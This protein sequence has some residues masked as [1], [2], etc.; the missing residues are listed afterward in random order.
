MNYFDKKRER[1]FQ[2]N[3]NLERFLEEVNKDLWV[4]EKELMVENRPLFPV[5][6]IVGPLRSGSTLLMQWLANLG[7][8]SYPTNLLSRFYKAPII[9]AKIQL[10]L[11][12][13]RYNF[14]DEL[15]EFSGGVDFFSENGK[16]KG[17]LAPN[18]FWYFWRRFLPYSELDY[19]PTE[20]LLKQSDTQTM[21]A[22][23]A[24]MMSVFKKPMALKAMILNYNVDFLDQLFEKA[25][26]IH[27]T[28]DPLTNIASAL[29]ARKKQ[30]GSL[31][32]WYSFKIPEYYELKK[33]NPYEQVAGQI[34][35]INKAVKKELVNVA[36][37]KKMTFNYEE[38]C[39]DPSEFYTLLCKKLSQNSYDVKG[40]YNLQKSFEVTRKENVSESILNAS[41]LFD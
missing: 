21:I 7:V 38:F 11:A 16:T 26:F 32:E 37:H 27:T 22:E 36:E 18:E 25:I 31:D 35:Y 34:H 8:L 13:S 19:V 33:L 9:G 39:A 5:I 12:D 3:Q 15:M 10:L 17:A 30:L 4:T 41:R 29:D 23:L 40:D 28:R 2:R 20:Q 14:R 24:G 1:L 6:F